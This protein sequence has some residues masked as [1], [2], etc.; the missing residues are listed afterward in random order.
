[1]MR[2][3]FKLLEED[4]GFEIITEARRCGMNRLSERS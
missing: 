4:L 2:P 3:T 1:M